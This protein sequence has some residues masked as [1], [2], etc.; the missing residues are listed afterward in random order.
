MQAPLPF[1][2]RWRRHWP[3]AAN[4]SLLI[5]YP[6]AWAAPLARAGVL[7]F[8][9]GTELTI[10]NGVRD[11]WDADVF[12][13]VIVAIFAVV[14]PYLKTIVLAAIQLGRLRGS[15]WVRVVSIAGKLSMADIFLLALYVVLIKG[16]GV[17]HVETA[18]GL[19]LFTTLVLVSLFLAHV[20]ERR[21]KKEPASW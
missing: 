10:L 11:L 15:G 5:L 6:V 7:P 18:W 17:G 3:T 13:A 9:S 8:F 2:E 16:V 14:A 12:L 4:L 1:R 21:L 19:Y 20:A